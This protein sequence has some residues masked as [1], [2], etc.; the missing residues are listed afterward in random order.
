MQTCSFIVLTCIRQAC[1][2][3]LKNIWALF[4]GKSGGS[5]TSEQIHQLELQRRIFISSPPIFHSAL[6]PRRQPSTPGLGTDRDVEPQAWRESNFNDIRPPP[7]LYSPVFRAGDEEWSPFSLAG[8]KRQVSFKKVEGKK[9]GRNRL[10][11]EQQQDV[12][13]PNGDILLCAA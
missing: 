13:K 6:L 8:N 1:L 10:S 12:S 5:L 7:M 4:A 2:C 3:K 11:V 9:Q